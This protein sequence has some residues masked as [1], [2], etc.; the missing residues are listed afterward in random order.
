M[1]FVTLIPLAIVL[2]ACQASAR[3]EPRFDPNI[4]YGQIEAGSFLRLEVGVM[5]AGMLPP[6]V[7]IEWSVDTADVGEAST[8]SLRALPGTPGAIEYRPP[9]GARGPVVVRAELRTE[10]CAGDARASRACSAEF[11][12]NV[13]APEP[14]TLRVFVG[15]NEPGE[16]LLQWTAAGT[17]A[18]RWQYRYRPRFERTDTGLRR[19]AS[20]G[21]WM[22][23]PHSD[24]DTR[25]HRVTG[26]LRGFHVFQVRGWTATG[27]GIVYN[28]VEALAS[29]RVTKGI[30]Q[31]PV[32]RLL[33]SGRRIAWGACSFVVPH[34]MHVEIPNTTSIGPQY[35]GSDAGI[36]LR[37]TKS[38]SYMLV[39]A[40]TC[41][42]VLRWVSHSGPDLTVSSP[43]PRNVDALFKQIV[44]SF[45]KISLP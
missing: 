25:N 14:P 37:D 5:P 41:E 2:S 28:P 27:A 31:V 13:V 30:V 12:L 38:G 33:E 45:E 23:V 9:A 4:D 35:A 7:V 44:E 42:L 15:G 18:I 6:E 19:L 43:R 11:A 17:E 26:L 36:R 20:W 8:S 32:G 21:D 1:G 39:N 24:S 29:E 22:D 34:G 10:D 3:I 16:F 40:T